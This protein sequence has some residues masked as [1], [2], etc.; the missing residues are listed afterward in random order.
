[1]KKSLFV[2]VFMFMLSAYSDKLPDGVYMISDKEAA[3]K[4]A[5]EKQRPIA[6]VYTSLKTT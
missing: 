6:I 1:M 5:R 3:F 2:L 4:E